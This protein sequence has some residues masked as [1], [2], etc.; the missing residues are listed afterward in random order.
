[1][2]IARLVS[3]LF[4]A[5]A[6]LVPAISSALTADE[7]RAQIQSY[8]D[9]IRA[10]QQQLN[11]LRRLQDATSTPPTPLPRLRERRACALLTRDIP[12][13]STS[14]VVRAIQEALAEDRTIY[15]DGLTTGYFGPLTQSALQRLRDRLIAQGFATTTLPFDEHTRIGPWLRGLLA[16][17]WCSSAPPPFH[18]GLTC[19]LPATT[20]PT[21]SCAGMWER[22][23]GMRGCHVGWRCV[24]IAHTLNQQP[25]IQNF[26]GPTQLSVHEPGTWTVSASD[27][28]N[29]ALT[30]RIMWGDESIQ[31]Q[32]QSFAELDAGVFTSTTTFTHT[33]GSVGRYA[34]HIAVRD[35]AGNTAHAIATVKVKPPDVA[36]PLHEREQEAR[37]PPFAAPWITGIGVQQPDIEKV[38]VRFCPFLA[39]FKRE[40]VEG[41]EGDDVR[42]LQELLHA[43]K[44]LNVAPTGYFGPLTRNALQGWQ[45]LLADLPV[46]MGIGYPPGTL[47]WGTFDRA[48]YEQAL[49]HLRA[50]CQGAVDLPVPPAQEE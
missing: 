6:V 29:D 24:P 8:H 15:P 13:G 2:R 27:P 43:G 38:R 36:L 10:L 18:P 3:T 35:S 16:R 48:T 31:E 33:Y 5:V 41:A 34:V 1:M 26:E 14:D 23:E 19:P 9:Q 37:I 20:T 32:L 39:T 45:R 50:W 4:V 12:F 28:E 17:Y 25:S 44:F 49:Q 11:E 7:I 21:E 40:L 30:Y 22:L 47:H 42:N 46:P